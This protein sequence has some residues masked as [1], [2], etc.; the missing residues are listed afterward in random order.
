MQCEKFG[1]LSAINELEGYSRLHYFVLLAERGLPLS[2]AP[3]PLLLI[4]LLTFDVL[5][6][7]CYPAPW[8]R[9]ANPLACCFGCWMFL[10]DA[11]WVTTAVSHSVCIVQIV[12]LRSMKEV[13]GRKAMS[14]MYLEFVV[15]LGRL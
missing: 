14:I 7:G 10:V 4:G 6:P 3:L 13:P 11:V 2:P 12:S 8:H 1:F 9:L 15:S 5:W